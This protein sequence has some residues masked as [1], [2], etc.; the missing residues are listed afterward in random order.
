MKK[1]LLLMGIVITI[2]SCKSK[3]TT[4]GGDST[5]VTTTQA[6]PPFQITLNGVD[7]AL[8]DTMQKHFLKY[9]AQDTKPT[10]ESI[11]FD[12]ATIVKIVALLDQEIKDQTAAPH[13]H[14]TDTTDGI[15]IYFT[16]DIAVTTGKLK[17]S[18]ILVS[19][20]NGGPDPNVDSKAIHRD[21]YT[22]NKSNPLF[23]NL[24][25]IQGEIHTRDLVNLRGENLYN[26]CVNCDVVTPCGTNRRHYLTR[27]RAHQMVNEFGDKAI[28]TNSEWFDINLFRAFAHDNVL[29][30]IRIYFTRHP[31]KFNATPDPNKFKDAFVLVTTQ[32][33]LGIHN[34]YF[35]CKATNKYF[36]YY[37]RH[38]LLPPPPIG[39]GQDNG[40]LCPDS[41][42]H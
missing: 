23:A 13:Q 10:R 37:D 2:A 3:A 12:K 42:E 27:K 30:G 6:A 7:S 16:S 20:K 19:T 1:L 32:K 18:I 15:R 26:I 31:E 4:N 41:C 5:Q 24:S 25:S 22:H 9:R 21:Y 33:L 35:N 28:T 39:G 17:N 40:E 8:A 34:D 11:W 38:N 29:D 36:E 14:R